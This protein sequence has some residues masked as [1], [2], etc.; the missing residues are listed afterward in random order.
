ML[1]LSEIRICLAGPLAE[2]KV[3]GK[4]LRALGAHTDLR[5]AL[6]IA[7]GLR[8]I[9][10]RLP[11]GIDDTPIAVTE[12]L[13]QQRLSVRRWLGQPKTWQSITRIARE[14]AVRHTLD[15]ETLHWV[16]SDLKPERPIAP[17]TK[18]DVVDGSGFK[19]A[20]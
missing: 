9:R 6:L 2:S 3:L 18:S 1:I 13:K 14:L 10:R 8:N 20:A 5:R 12:L 16:L 17:G 7:R 11:S 4:D 15:T 19:R